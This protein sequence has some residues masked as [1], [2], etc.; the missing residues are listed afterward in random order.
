MGTLTGAAR[1][2]GVIGWPVAH[3]RSPRLHGH[4]LARHGVD[5]AYVPLAVAP[6]RLE[7]AVRGLHAAGF[8][9]CNVTIPHKQAVMALCDRVDATAHR[10]GAV[11]TLVFSP[12]G[13]EGSNTDGSG[14]LANLR[15]HGVDPAAGPAL[16]LGA[17][18]GARAIAAAL[19]DCGIA[20]T[21]A[22]RTPARAE[23]LAAALPGVRV[24]PWEAREAAVADQALLVN[25]TQLGMQGQ[26]PL[27]MALDRCG[28]GAGGVG[29]RL[30]PAR[31][32]AAG[33][34]RCARPAHGERHRHAAAS[35]GAGL[36]GV[37]RGDA[38]GRRRTRA[39]RARVKT[40][41]LTGGI[42]MGKS[43]AAAAFR[44]ARLPVFDADAEVHR[45]QARGGA[46][47]AAI[48]AAFPGVVVGG[49]VDRGRLRAAAVQDPAAMATLERILHPMVRA[50]ERRFVAAARRVRA[51][52]V[53]LDIPLLLE[54]GGERRVDLV[55]VVSAP[56]S[57]QRAR[58]RARRR[59]TDAQIAAIVARQM[60]DREKRRR[61]DV[62][63]R[64]GLSRYHANRML[65]RLI[66]HPPPAP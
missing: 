56:A 62:V 9:G 66:R 5:G 6:E 46:A 18:G 35:G 40:I 8:R 15:A 47:V 38:D 24:V 28:A 52:A 44:R 34:C 16:I 42:G 30:C 63:V 1:V 60:P 43:T 7:A 36:C 48:E 39:G 58:V 54:T 41:G 13:I 55:V 22:N 37:V 21:V 45:L 61:A 65:H 12:D 19:R 53:V 23:A 64:T 4:W 20:V 17:G 3:S 14:F 27:A 31:D 57:V 29:H 10:A 32:C 50:A 51:R 2:A 26:P 11:N 59:M 33:R 49:A 25:T